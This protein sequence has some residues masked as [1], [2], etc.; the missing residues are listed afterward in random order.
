MV[1]GFCFLNFFLFGH[2]GFSVHHAGSLVV[3]RELGCPTAGGILVPW[4]GIKLAFPALEGGFFPALG[5]GFL[6]TR[7]PGKF[8]AW[9]VAGPWDLDCDQK[10]GSGSSLAQQV[11]WVQK[12]DPSGSSWHKPPPPAEK[13]PAHL[14]WGP[15]WRFWGSRAAVVTPLWWAWPIWT[16]IP[17]FPQT[18]QFLC[19]LLLLLQR[20]VGCFPHFQAPEL[21]WVRRKSNS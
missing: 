13:D 6:T 4:P 2:A 14:S 11:D 18:N 21:S 5:G 7:T 1:L 19:S 12:H 8:Q 20:G 9:D 17:L 10:E 16:I 15:A 3:A